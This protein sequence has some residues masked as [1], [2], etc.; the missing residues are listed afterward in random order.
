MT[1]D[2]RKLFLNKREIIENFTTFPMFYATY[3]T[4]SL[5]LSRIILYS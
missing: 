3:Y 1:F 4:I 2:I 5:C